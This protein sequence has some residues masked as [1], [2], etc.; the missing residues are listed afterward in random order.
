MDNQPIQGKTHASPNLSN[1]TI[2][3]FM[4]ITDGVAIGSHG[5]TAREDGII[6][7][8]V[9]IVGSRFVFPHL[10]IQI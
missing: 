7:A 5:V 3:G 10:T 6:A 8:T 2:G 1:R 4:L 9:A